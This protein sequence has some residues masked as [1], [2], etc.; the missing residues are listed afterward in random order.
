MM[1]EEIQVVIK[2][3]SGGFDAVFPGTDHALENKRSAPAAKQGPQHGGFRLDSLNGRLRPDLPQLI[4]D[5][6]NRDR[7]QLHQS[8]GTLAR[9]P[10]GIKPAFDNLDGAQEFGTDDMLDIVE[11]GMTEDGLGDIRE[12][13]PLQNSL[14]LR[15]VIPY[16]YRMSAGDGRD[17]PGDEAGREDPLEFIPQRAGR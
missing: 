11:V 15:R 10:L 16:Q 9:D 1:A 3:I 2:Q 12:Q 5:L 14:D 13:I 6:F 7:H 4:I 8:P 17:R